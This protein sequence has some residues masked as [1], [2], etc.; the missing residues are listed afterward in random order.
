MMASTCSKAS[1]MAQQ[2]KVFPTEADNPSV[3][4]RIH[5]VG[6]VFHKVLSH[7]HM[8][9]MAYTQNKEI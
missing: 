5:T 3:M 1:E 7:F 2:T 4:L 8:Y 6:S 9:R